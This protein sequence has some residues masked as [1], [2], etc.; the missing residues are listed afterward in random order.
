[1]QVAALAVMTFCGVALGRQHGSDL[2]SVVAVPQPFR[3]CAAWFG[4]SL[5]V[6]VLDGELRARRVPRDVNREPQIRAPQGLPFDPGPA[7]KSAGTWHVID[8]SGGWLVGLDHG[9]FLGGLWWFSEDGAATPVLSRLNVISVFAQ[10]PAQAVVVTDD[11]SRGGAVIALTRV[12]GAWRRDSDVALNGR[13]LAAAEVGRRSFVVLGETRVFWLAGD[14]I[15]RAV[16]VPLLT[17]GMRPFLFSRGA[18]GTLF[19]GMSL[20]ALAVRTDGSVQ[21]LAEEGCERPQ[22]VPSPDPRGR[23]TPWWKACVCS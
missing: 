9:E 11:G 5:D 12:D 13:P 20:H 6:R 17:R 2:V 19:A 18:D 21:W 16:D 15:V 7:F 1:M 4:H 8:T 3:E 22:L 14:A 10:D 23:Q